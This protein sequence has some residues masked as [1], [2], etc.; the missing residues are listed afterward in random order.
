MAAMVRLTTLAGL[1][2]AVLGGFGIGK[3]G[4]LETV[5]LAGLGC[6]VGL[7]M[8]YGASQVQRTLLWTSAVCL[9]V[10]GGAGLV[11]ARIPDEQ[12]LVSA[13]RSVALNPVILAGFAVGARL[14]WFCLRWAARPGL[15]PVAPSAAS[16]PAQPPARTPVAGSR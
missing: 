2:V 5:L 8:G 13:V 1:V 6:L 16:H 12:T 9:V 15:G 7:V 3:I 10:G 14:S 4:E 11:V